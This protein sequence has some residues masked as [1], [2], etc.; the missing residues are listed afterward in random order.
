MNLR[1]VYLAALTLLSPLLSA[2]KGPLP[3]DPPKP[4]GFY[5]VSL[6]EGEHGSINIG[7]F[8]NGAQ[9]LDPRVWLDDGDDNDPEPDDYIGIRYTGQGVDKTILRCTSWDGITIAVGRHKGIVA[10]RNLTV[11]AGADRATAFGQQQVG[12]AKVK[13]P[14]FQINLNNVRFVARPPGADG[15]RTK[16]L[17]FSYNAD[18]FLRDCVFDGSDLAEHDLYAHGFAKSGM[19][20]E[21]CRF[22]S[23]GAEQLKVRSDTTET[24]W[25]GPQAKVI[26]RDSRFTN[27]HQPHSW[28]GGAGIVLQGA[29]CD[30]LIERCL[31]IGGR[32]LGE[33]PANDR[34]K[35]IMISSEGLSYDAVTGVPNVGFGTGHVVIRDCHL[36]GHSDV[37]WR[38][39]I[40]RVDRNGGSQQA[41]RSVLIENCGVWGQ[42]MAVTAGN[43]PAGKLTIR[44]CNTPE[45]RARSE[46]LGLDTTLQ[47][48][49][50]TSTR[51]V[52]LVE[53]ISR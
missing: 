37:D 42:N 1:L 43:I 38:N 19:L 47:A 39:T 36:W 34:S 33:I 16:W 12:T 25:A 44:G 48:Y 21:R 7:W 28:R 13:E 23:S 2:Q 40:I 14:G 51:K 45:I 3:S 22:N 31:L 18:L 27:W 17:V 29:G 32:A 41:A 24:V 26:V 15:K 35:A 46:S 52:P 10:F 50:P 8:K 6:A 49:F 30:V 9:I 11:Y 53:G 5:E 4:K 20:V